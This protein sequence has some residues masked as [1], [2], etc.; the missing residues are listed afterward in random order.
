MEFHCLAMEDLPLPPKSFEEWKAP[1]IL[2]LREDRI[3]CPGCVDQERRAHKWLSQILEI[4][5]KRTF[6][7]EQ[8]LKLHHRKLRFLDNIY[9]IVYKINAKKQQ[10]K[11]DLRIAANCLQRDSF[12]PIVVAVV[13]KDPMVGA[14]AANEEDLYA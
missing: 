13:T 9:D 7:E 11:L 10:I 4:K 8:E 1:W 12:E 5:S 2:S 6:Q 3:H 14:T